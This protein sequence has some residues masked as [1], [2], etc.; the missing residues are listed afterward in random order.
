M[1]IEHHT[2]TYLHKHRDRHRNRNRDMIVMGIRGKW[3]GGILEEKIDFFIE[4]PTPYASLCKVENRY[5]ILLFF[6]F[7]FELISKSCAL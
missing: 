3:I 6:C 5:V 2:Y 7:F 4:L 1:S